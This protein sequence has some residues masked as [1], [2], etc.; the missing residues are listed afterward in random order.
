M[1]H[2]KR[3]F[4]FPEKFIGKLASKVGQRRFVC[5]DKEFE[6]T[7]R[8]LSSGANPEETPEMQNPSVRS[9]A[10]GSRQRCRR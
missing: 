10:A 4:Q 3:Q 7:P 8:L 1:K 5:A 2:N 9:A 6:S